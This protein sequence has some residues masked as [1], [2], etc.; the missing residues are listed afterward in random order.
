MK[1]ITMIVWNEF[2][3]DARVLKQ[4]QTLQAAGYQVTVFAL[5][6]PG[7]TRQKKPSAMESG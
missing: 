3:H 4:A 2:R 7:V 1:K 5:H 6:T